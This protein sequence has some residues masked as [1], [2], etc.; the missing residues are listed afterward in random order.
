MQPK[1]GAFQYEP[2]QHY[3]VMDMR[4]NEGNACMKT[5]AEQLQNGVGSADFAPIPTPLLSAILQGGAFAHVV[6]EEGL[7][8]GV[9]DCTAS[10]HLWINP[11]PSQAELNVPPH[12][13]PLNFHC[14]GHRV[15][16]VNWR[17][18]DVRVNSGMV[19]AAHGSS[20][21]AYW[22]CVEPDSENIRLFEK[23]MSAAT[24]TVAA[25]ASSSNSPETRKSYTID[26]FHAPRLAS[27]ESLLRAGVRMRLVTQHENDLVILMSGTPHCVFTPP[28][29]TKVSRNWVTPQ[30]LLSAAVRA[31]DSSSG[32]RGN[33]IGVMQKKPLQCL[34]QALARIR[35]AEPEQFRRLITH[36]ASISHLCRALSFAQ[37]RAI[38]HPSDMR[39]LRE[40][41]NQIIEWM[42]PACALA[43]AATMPRSSSVQQPVQE[44]IFIPMD[45]SGGDTDDVDASPVSVCTPTP[46]PI[47]ASAL[48][49]AISVATVISSACASSLLCKCPPRLE[50]ALSRRRPIPLCP[51]LP[52][53]IRMPYS[54]S[55]PTP[56][57]LLPWKCK[58]SLPMG[59][60]HQLTVRNSSYTL[61]LSSASR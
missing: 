9:E 21:P 60:S 54:Q 18:K 22:L 34:F 14:E 29:A 28:A 23:V 47:S 57:R 25:A 13:L 15:G 10:H 59:C 35:Q 31:I 61:S 38:T 11:A 42:D 46:S 5:L 40:L 7:P 1:R 43:A 52:P 44:S 20:L 51:A 6:V 27:M 39:S 41:T 8:Y 55:H 58:A 53:P 37:Q 3:F 24:V 45:I 30:A 50:S 19:T 4:L 17:M 36:Q 12:Y 32:E 49:P 16:A 56:L 48:L 2:N 26:D 33:L